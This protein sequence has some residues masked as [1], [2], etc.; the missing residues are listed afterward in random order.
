[1]R[2]RRGDAYP[3]IIRPGAWNVHHQ[4]RG[5][6]TILTKRELA[7]PMDDTPFAR[8]IRAHELAHVRFS[9]ARPRPKSWQADHW[10]VLAVEDARVNE[11]LARRG[12]GSL[13]APLD[14]PA[15]GHLDPRD[16]LRGATLLLVAAHGT[17]AFSRLAAIYA[18]SGAAGTTALRLTE[19]ALAMLHA[20]G[21]SRFRDTLTVARFLDRMLGTAP[22]TDRAFLCHTLGTPADDADG[23]EEPLD[24][25]D[26][27]RARR[28]SERTESASTSWGRLRAVEEPALPVRASIA[29]PWRHRAASEGTLLRSVFRLHLD[30]RV[31]ARRVRRQGG[32]VLIDGSGS[33]SLGCDDVMA[34]LA[35]APA[36]L[37]ARYDGDPSAGVGVIRVLARSGRRV[38]DALIGAHCCGIGNVIDGP[39]LR[40]L[41]AQPAPRIWVSDGRVTGV[42]DRGS[43]QLMAEARAICDTHGIVRVTDAAGARAAVQGTRAVAVSR[44]S[45]SSSR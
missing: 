43:S 33:M 37:V 10:T 32:T 11:L 9:P 23:A 19:R 22:C 4:N 14:D 18:D 36:A 39:A 16:D 41:A 26:V 40:W 15:N 8:G 34:I 2:T 13:L 21:R 28:R 29:A 17:G 6:H 5:G 7:A 42:R 30:G 3:E 35:A 27:L 12:L 25:D 1:M 38:N 31:F 24:L 20:P 44:P 45:A